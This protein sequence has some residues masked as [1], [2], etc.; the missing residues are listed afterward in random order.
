MKTQKLVAGDRV[1]LTAKFLKNTG[2]FTGPAGQRRGT[3]VKYESGAL[4][5]FARVRWDDFESVAARFAELYGDDFVADAREH[6]S[7][8][9]AANI[10]KVGA[11]KFACNDIG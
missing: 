5:T 4:D 1:A 11:A 10:C 9:L 3:F 6:G 7:V 8:V 2:Q